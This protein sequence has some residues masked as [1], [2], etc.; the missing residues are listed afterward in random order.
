M[1]TGAGPGTHPLYLPG[2]VYLAG[3]YQGAPLSFVLI[4]PAVSG[5]YDLGN[6][7]VRAALQVDPETAQVTTV[8]DPLPQI[9]EG[10]PLRLRSD[11]RQPQPPRFRP[12]PDQLQATRGHAEVFGDEGATSQSPTTLPGRQLRRP[13]PSPPSSPWRLSGSTKRAGHP[14]LTADPDR[15]AG[16][17]QYRPTPVTLPP[18]ELLD[19]AHIN[20]S[21]H[22]RPVRR[23]SRVKCPPYSLLG[24]PGPR[25]RFSPSPSKD[26]SIC[27]PPPRSGLPDIVAALDGQIDIDLDGRV[28]SVD[29]RLR[30]TFETVPD[31]PVPSS[32]CISTAAARGSWKTAP[33]LCSHTLHGNG[34]H[35]VAKTARLPARI[36][37]L[38]PP[39]AQS[40]DKRGRPAHSS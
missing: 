2:R 14:A 19:N 15:Q 13:R 18:T 30:T 31:A 26:R 8:S 12:Q 38:R 9:F 11:P 16:R 21:L 37:V 4:T 39:A 10:I 3:P 36:P 23:H 5:G 35:R 34:D 32:T 29:G 22:P 20:D 25:P 40:S 17:S 33:G 28:D 7:V 6:V 1:I 27:A 24:T